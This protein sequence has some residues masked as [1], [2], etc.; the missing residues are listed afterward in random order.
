MPICALVRLERCGEVLA[1]DGVHGAR[2]QLLEAGDHAEDGGLAAARGAEKAHEFAALDRETEV[3]DDGRPAEGARPKAAG[4][5][6]A[7]L[8]GFEKQAFARRLA[9]EGK[10]G[11]NPFAAAEAGRT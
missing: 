8:Q 7:G 10:A 1:F 6:W 5:T 4:T 3:L 11:L 2:V 9:Y